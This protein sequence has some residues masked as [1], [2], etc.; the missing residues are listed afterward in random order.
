MNDPWSTT[1]ITLTDILS[2]RSGLPRHD[3][4]WLA[5]I[6]LQDTVQ[7]IRHL[8]LTAASRTEWQY[9]N[10][11]YNTATHLIEKMTNQSIHSFL[12]ENIW[13]PLDMTE[14]YLSFSEAQDAGRDISQGYYV[15]LNGDILPT[16]RVYTEA[17]RGAGN[18]LSS[19][20]DYAKWISALLARQPPISEAGY[21][22]LLGAHTIV[23]ST[24]IE[25]FS[26][27][28][29]YGFGWMSRSY[30]GEEMIYHDG[31][32]YGYGASVVFLPR[33]KFGLVV[34]GNNMN[35]V[36]AAANV[37]SYHLVDEELGIPTDKR[38][39][40]ISR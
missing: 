31:A 6:T 37:L 5:D 17:L 9:C 12:K 3:W 36:S 25:P 40:W 27:P 24:P 39:D 18:T 8:P 21:T 16:N 30:G 38:F 15:D 11:M 19:V 4:V 1:H 23:S 20:S 2:H 35:G 33:R 13:G 29:V 32:Q 26:S 28:E 14:T 34:L 22:A 10:L 7:S